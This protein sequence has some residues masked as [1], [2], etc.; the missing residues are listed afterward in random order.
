MHNFELP[1]RSS[2]P[3]LFL[4]ALHNIGSEASVQDL[5]RVRNWRGKADAFRVDVVERLKRCRLIDVT[6][7]W[8]VLTKQG[9]D[10]LG[11]ALVISGPP[12]EPVGAPYTGA[13]NPL[14]LSR[15]CA[16]RPIRAGAL[17]Y[18]KLPSRIGVESVAYK[19]QIAASAIAGSVT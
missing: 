14:N 16:P 5:M 11:V 9:L 13:K 3:F 7:D 15:H 6:G 17:D 4:R 18:M 19:G 1:R 2:T 12:P 8:L 10:Y